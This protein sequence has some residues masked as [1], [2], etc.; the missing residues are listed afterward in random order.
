MYR[1]QPGMQQQRARMPPPQMQQQQQRMGGNSGMPAGNYQQQPQQQMQQGGGGQP[2][3]QQPRGQPPQQQAPPPQVSP[4][5]PQPQKSRAC[6]TNDKI[7]KSRFATKESEYA[8]KFA[9]RYKDATFQSK[10]KMPEPFIWVNM[11]SQNLK[12]D[13][14]RQRDNKKKGKNNDDYYRDREPRGR[15]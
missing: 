3:Q 2:S 1:P 15:Y 6:A 12:S 8:T 14:N 13:R 10:E 5:I 4:Q 9:N 7:E 11:P